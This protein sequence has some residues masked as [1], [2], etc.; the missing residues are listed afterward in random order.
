MRRSTALCA[1]T[2][3]PF[4]FNELQRQFTGYSQRG[5]RLFVMFIR[6]TLDCVAHALVKTKPSWGLNS[7]RDAGYKVAESSP[8]HVH[9]QR[10]ER[11]W[12]QS[13][14]TVYGTRRELASKSSVV[15]CL[16]VVTWTPRFS[17][18]AT[19]CGPG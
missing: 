10:N 15:V 18:P 4:P 5:K 13:R 2:S 12:T 8:V 1:P 6:N 19:F 11:T 14:Y 7:H 16:K 9:L 3:F 17:L